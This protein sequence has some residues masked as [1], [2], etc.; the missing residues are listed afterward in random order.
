[1]EAIT[2]GSIL[3]E[4]LLFV[5]FNTWNFHVSIISTKLQFVSYGKQ[6]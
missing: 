1:M 3:L 2:L 5:D 4:L 6:V